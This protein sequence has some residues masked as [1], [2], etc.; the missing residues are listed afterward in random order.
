MGTQ[1]TYTYSIEVEAYFVLGLLWIGLICRLMRRL[2]GLP[3]EEWHL[4]PFVPT[5]ESFGTTSSPMNIIEGGVN[6]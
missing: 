2:D 4:K 6:V 5:L 1:K 3:I